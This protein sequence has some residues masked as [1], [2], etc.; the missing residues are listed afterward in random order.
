MTSALICWCGPPYF[1]RRRQSLRLVDEPGC[2][3]RTASFEVLLQPPSDQVLNANNVDQV[4]D[5][6]DVVFLVLLTA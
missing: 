2:K 6:A 4:D 5:A 3:T 1:L